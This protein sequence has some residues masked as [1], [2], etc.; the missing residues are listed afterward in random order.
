[1]KTL[2]V[3]LLFAFHL[4]NAQQPTYQTAEWYDSVQWDNRQVN[5][6]PTPPIWIGSIAID[7]ETAK[8]Y[9]FYVTT[10]PDTVQERFSDDY[11]S[12]KKFHRHKYIPTAKEKR[13]DDS[14]A[15]RLEKGLPLIFSGSGSIR[16]V[17]KERHDKNDKFNDYIYAN[18]LGTVQ[19]AWGWWWYLMPRKPTEQDFIK[20]FNKRKTK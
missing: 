10:T 11:P 4:G 5:L 6:K 17:D 9:F 19:D 8:E 12:N 16:R 20:W 15:A 7:A 2:I 3:I 13:Q 1:M 14:I 18:N